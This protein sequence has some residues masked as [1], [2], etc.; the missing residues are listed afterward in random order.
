M[1]ADER[2][3]AEEQERERADAATAA[4]KAL[5]ESEAD[6]FRAVEDAT[7]AF[8]ASAQRKHVRGA[9]QFSKSAAH[10]NWPIRGMQ[11]SLMAS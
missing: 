4:H 1:Q 5:R 10:I 8:E 6:R 7:N 9:F 11:D 3:R 2:A